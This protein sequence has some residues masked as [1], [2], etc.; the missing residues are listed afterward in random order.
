MGT[1]NSFSNRLGS[2]VLSN[3]HG[4][5]IYQIF[6]ERVL[7]LIDDPA[8]EVWKSVRDGLTGTET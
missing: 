7:T 5:T 1:Y 2:T 8:K 4:D 3:S 6:L